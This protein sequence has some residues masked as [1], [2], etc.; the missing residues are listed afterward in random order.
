M[1]EVT[2]DDEK[3][4]E[5]CCLLL[6][7]LALAALAVSLSLFGGAGT[8]L[9]SYSSSCELPAGSMAGTS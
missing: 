9:H 3:S 1:T 8:Q 4:V 2:S 7:P 6:T 5:V